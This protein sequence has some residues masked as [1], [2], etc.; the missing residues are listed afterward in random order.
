MASTKLHVPTL[1]GVVLCIIFFSYP[2]FV[3]FFSY[4]VVE[5]FR[6]NSHLLYSSVSIQLSLVPMLL[7][8]G[9]LHHI[10]FI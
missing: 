9:T 3:N 8:T 4:Y 10:P 6:R 2:H 1:T 5:L 7:Q